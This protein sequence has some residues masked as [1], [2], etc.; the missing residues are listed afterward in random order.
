[1]NNRTCWI[2]ITHISSSFTIHKFNLLCKNS[3]SLFFLIFSLIFVLFL[4]F[5]DIWPLFPLSAGRNHVRAW[6]LANHMPG[7]WWLF[8]RNPSWWLFPQ[9][10]LHIEMWPGQTGGEWGCTEEKETGK[11]GS[12]SSCS[13]CKW[14]YAWSCRFFTNNPLQYNAVGGMDI[15]TVHYTVAVWAFHLESMKFQTPLD[16]K[17]RGISWVLLHV[18][19]RFPW[20]SALF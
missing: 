17:P 8:R 19:P 14:P 12:C 9:R 16:P 10:G 3:H 7:E 1:M 6:I 13:G 20:G 4:F 11:A 15:R 2:R 18:H 5:S